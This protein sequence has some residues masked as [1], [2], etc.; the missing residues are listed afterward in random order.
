MAKLSS[1]FGKDFL[2]FINKKTGRVHASYWQIL[3]TGRISVSDPNLNQIPSK[4]ELA[5]SI[6]AAF[7]PE[8]GI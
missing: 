5:K 2:K 7:I 3:S 8:D 6:R 4:G 1:A